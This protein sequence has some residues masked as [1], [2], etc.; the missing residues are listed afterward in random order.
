MNE[1]TEKHGDEF[2]FIPLQFPPD[3]IEIDY[4]RAAEIFAAQQTKRMI[5]EI[6]SAHTS[7]LYG[8]FLDVTPY[9]SLPMGFPPHGVT[10]NATTAD[11][12]YGEDILTTMFAVKL[13][14]DSCDLA[15]ST[16]ISDPERL[17]LL[18]MVRDEVQKHIDKLSSDE[19]PAEG[20]RRAEGEKGDV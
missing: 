20:N 4:H 8:K 11:P 18:T 15:T 16:R 17:R 3:P 7:K 14:V 9:G 13:M 19:T 1:P 10:N 12:C 6:D 5:K 2:P